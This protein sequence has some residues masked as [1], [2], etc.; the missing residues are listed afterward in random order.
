M[1]MNQPPPGEVPDLT[2]LTGKVSVGLAGRRPWLWRFLG[3]CLLAPVV[4]GPASLA[5]GVYLE[6]S[7]SA[8]VQNAWLTAS[9]SVA[10][11]ADTIT[12]VPVA[13]Q[14]VG[15]TVTV[16]ASSSSGLE[17]FFGSETLP[18]CT[19]KG[20]AVTT[21][22]AG[23]CT[24]RAS[25]K[26]GADAT[27][28]FQVQAA[29]TITFGPPPDAKVGAPVT[30]SASA[31]SGLPVSFSSGTT[32]VCT[33]AGS[34]VTTA[35]AGLC[36]ITASQSGNTDYAAAP[37]V[38]QSFQVNPVNPGS[39]AQTITFGQ[40]PDAK[41]G[42]PVTLSASA[43]SGLPV[44]FSSGTT[45]VC[46]VAG[47]AVTTAAAGLCTITASQSGN[48]DYAAAPP[49]TQS[50]QVNPVN[51][52]SA[53]QTITF[54][55]P[56]DAKV[57]A[58][59]T[60]S[61]SASSGLPVSFSSGTTPVC[62]VA[63]SAVTT[64]AAGLCTITASQSGNT[65]YAAAPPVTQ[66]FQ[67]NPVNPGSAAQTITFGQPPDAKVGA[68]VTL[69]A[70]AS[71]GLPVSFSSGTTPVCTVAGSTV[72]TVAAGPCTITASQGGSARYAAAPDVR[73][74]FQVKPVPPK[75]AGVRVILLAG[76][77]LAAAAATMV[78]RRRLRSHPQAPTPAPNVRAVPDT[79]PPGLV[80]VHNTGTDA[81]H[82]VR[83]E[84][85]PGTSITTIEEA[86]P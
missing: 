11:A 37:P 35:A 31:S 66:S 26:D 40:P 25:D 41:V 77:I 33:V 15:A 32:P 65:D 61:A 54:G 18:V 10:A 49:V 45:P 4:G 79:G 21:A 47:S 52:G 5:G 63:G 71:S 39:A 9:V 82:T 1:D 60:L 46:T 42:A 67:V 38:T 73:Q 74:S 36:T 27:Q 16:S 85:S 24:I 14:I 76:V 3:I 51:P 17:V 43:S 68:P 34:A 55:Q 86:R 57:G 48:T 62:T 19:V 53:A 13:N 20:S 69:S 70:H 59:V 7:S 75:A 44:S 83:I 29:Q 84:P 80:S 2:G 6:T 30:L 22:A 28:S 64:A 8:K 12:F 78:L 81:T 72:T 23:L 50:F 56:P 58:P